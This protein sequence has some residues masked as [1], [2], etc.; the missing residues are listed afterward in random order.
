MAVVPACGRLLIVELFGLA[1][2]SPQMTRQ[3][4]ESPNAR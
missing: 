4:V 2:S 1:F 3:N